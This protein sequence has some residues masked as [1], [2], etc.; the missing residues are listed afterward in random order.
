MSIN[1]CTNTSTGDSSESLTGR[2]NDNFAG[3]KQIESSEI[4]RRM[5]RRIN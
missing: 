3:D 2:A 1:E 5:S 4:H